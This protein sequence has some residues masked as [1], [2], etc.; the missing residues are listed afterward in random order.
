MEDILEELV[1]EIQDEYD[2]ETAGVEKLAEG[3]YV[4][5]GSLTISDINDRL[6]DFQLP[7]GSDYT[8]LNGL[9]NKWFDRIPEVSEAC[10]RDGLRI[11]VLKT[12]NHHVEQVRIEH[13]EPAGPLSPQLNQPNGRPP[14]P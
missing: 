6:D 14:Q 11:T 4:V 8:T 12:E 9:V 5:Q 1:G 7:E 13:S 2:N 10:E 3:N